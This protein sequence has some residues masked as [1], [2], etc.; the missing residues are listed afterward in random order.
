[1]L[2]SAF[3]D[4]L[5][6]T[7][8][9]PVG[10]CAVIGVGYLVVKYWKNKDFRSKEL[11]LEF[12]AFLFFFCS[13]WRFGIPQ[14][15]YTLPLLIF[16]IVFFIFFVREIFHMRR[17]FKR[18][19]VWGHSVV[20][21][22]FIVLGIACPLKALQKKDEKIHLQAVPEILEK[23]H[24]TDNGKKNILLLV[25]GGSGGVIR[26]GNFDFCEIPVKNMSLH[27]ALV[28][29]SS[30]RDFEILQGYYDR[31]YIL[32]QESKNKQ[33]KE[34]WERVFSLKLYKEK[35]WP[36]KKKIY[37]LY[38]LERKFP[39][40]WD[41]MSELTAFF[42]KYNVVTNPD[43]S[44]KNI[45]DRAGISNDKVTVSAKGAAVDKQIVFP[46]GWEQKFGASQNLL[47]RYPEKERGSFLIAADKTVGI[48]GSGSKIPAGKYFVL[49]DL[50]SSLNRY[51]IYF[52]LFVQKTGVYRQNNNAFKS[53]T[54]YG[55]S[56]LEA[57]VVTIPEGMFAQ[58]AFYL[59]YGDAELR[60]FY[61]IPVQRMK[62]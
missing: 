6:K 16:V 60:G 33:F 17:I 1:M 55:F 5:M 18:Q 10:C 3:L 38:V 43:F 8:L 48:W 56:M 36:Q 4:G 35:E 39:K 15:R 12:I 25:C 29:F 22:F 49:L 51:A 54:P 19:F 32:C 44:Q 21:L 30:K 58:P 13:A 53:Y 40:K 57:F 50:K 20:M 28:Q 62:E 24:N 41:N 42:K 59:D 37:R 31:I 2:A 27:E 34:E 47:V 9:P 23:A 61:M 26:P 7:T 14:G 52:P 45:S 11:A 46:Y